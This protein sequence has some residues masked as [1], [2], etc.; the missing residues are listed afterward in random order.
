MEIR[1]LSAWLC[2]GVLLL[3]SSLMA[4]SAQTPPRPFSLEQVLSSPFPTNLVAV[5]N[6]GDRAGRI[7]WVFSARAERNVWIADAPNFE[8]RQ[9]THYVGDDG[10]PIAALKLTPDG[11]TVVYAR[12]SEANSAGEIA[13]PTS[14]ACASKKCAPRNSCSPMRFMGSSCGRAGF[15]RTARRRISLA[16]S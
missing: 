8:A 5:E 4:C 12:G 10:M 3:W 11:R 15:G 2:V 7:A 14:S 6:A 16:E 1:N 13:D 9:V